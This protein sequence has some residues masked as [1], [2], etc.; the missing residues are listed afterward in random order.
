MR[1]IPVVE[2]ENT[3]DGILLT[4]I[5]RENY[6]NIKTPVQIILQLLVTLAIGAVFMPGAFAD[7]EEEQKEAAAG[8]DASNPT[9]AVNFQDL[10][11]R[12]FDL[13]GDAGKHSFETE[14]AYVFHPRLKLRTNCVESAP[15]GAVTGKPTLRY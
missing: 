7:S 13:Q 15:I 8:A 10:R 2:A 6:V 4:L 14:G 5:H 9:A 12:Y 1:R 3:F 11:Y